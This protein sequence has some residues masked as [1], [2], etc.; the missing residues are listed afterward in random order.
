MTGNYSLTMEW[1]ASPFSRVTIAST[2]HR[3]RK[4]KTDYW[5]LNECESAF[6][7]K[8]QAQSI[9]TFIFRRRILA[10]IFRSQLF[11]AETVYRRMSVCDNDPMVKAKEY[12]E[13][14]KR[15]D[16]R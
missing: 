4:R 1:C 13:P 15:G 16:I 12:F 6:P 8:P 9:D 7:L 5:L 11:Y 2:A 10:R 14:E 3:N